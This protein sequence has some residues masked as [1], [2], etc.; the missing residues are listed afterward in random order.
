MKR[1][2]LSM[3]IA[4]TIAFAMQTQ[5]APRH[6]GGHGKHMDPKKM[7]EMKVDR[8]EK[9][10][11]LTADQKAAI[12]E[13]YLKEVELMNER[14]K[15][16]GEMKDKACGEMKDKACGEMK[17]KACGEMKGKACGEMKSGREEMKK[18]HE[19]INARIESVLN[20]EQKARFAEMEKTMSMG[21]HKKH[22]MKGKCGDNEKGQK[23]CKKG[24]GDCKKDCCN[25]GKSELKNVPQKQSLSKTK[26]KSFTKSDSKLE[27]K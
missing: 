3:V 10:L 25:E 21:H 13:I 7:V 8:M 19:A 12:T 18:H 16:C 14:A 23:D 1:I 2:F 26:A 6:H 27:K 5:A 4:L 24:E 22:G 20:D 9:E 15:A 11:N 17:D